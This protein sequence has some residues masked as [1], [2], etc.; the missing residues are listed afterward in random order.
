MS[1]ST[2]MF[3]HESPW[4]C[5]VWKR[6]AS[7]SIASS[8]SSRALS[9]G[10]TLLNTAASRRARMASAAPG[11]S[12]LGVSSLGPGKSAKA[13]G[14]HIISAPRLPPPPSRDESPLVPPPSLYYGHPL[15]QV[16]RARR[17]RQSARAGARD[18]AIYYV[19]APAQDYFRS[20]R[21]GSQKSNYP[22]TPVLV[23]LRIPRKEGKEGRC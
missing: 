5:H 11:I 16:T 18:S 15:H 2:K 10:G 4:V 12:G 8:S 19:R 22:G 6:C 23:L 3:M 14:L 9:P 1:R 17:T 20:C 21:P 13:C 7:T